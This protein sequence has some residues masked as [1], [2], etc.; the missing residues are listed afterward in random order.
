[1]KKLL[2]KLPQ[3]KIQLYFLVPD[4]IFETFPLQTYRTTADKKNAARDAGVGRTSRAM[5][6]KDA[7][8]ARG[9]EE[10]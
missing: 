9:L 4:D 1:M 7:N 6:F 5:G 3:G 8:V 2:Q 10:K